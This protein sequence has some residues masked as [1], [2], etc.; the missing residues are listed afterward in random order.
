ME[1]DGKK[2]DFE[3]IALAL[4]FNENH[5]YEFEKIES[6]IEQILLNHLIKYLDVETNVS[7]QV[8]FKTIGGTFRADIV[9]Q[10]GRKKVI[11]E[12]DGEEFHTQENNEWYDDWRDALLLKSLE[13]E[14]IYRIKGKDI[15]SN[16][17]EIIFILNKYEPDLLSHKKVISITESCKSTEVT[18]DS[19]RKNINIKYITEFEKE[20]RYTLEVK[21]KN[22]RNGYDIFWD[23]YVL[24]SSIFENKSIKDL[25]KIMKQEHFE[26]S[27]LF[28]MYNEKFRT[29]IT[30]I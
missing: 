11:L 20:V 13:V 10:K 9:L 18:E 19:F 2:I 28:R 8:D 5:S 29:N 3:N 30:S 16:I 15:Y 12:C 26:I 23:K 24:Y 4:L 25:M 17:N 22:L 21:R 1:I 6:P 14:T 7:V 27:T